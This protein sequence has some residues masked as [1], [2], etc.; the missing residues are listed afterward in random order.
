MLFDFD[1]PSLEWRECRIPKPKKPGEYRKLSIPNDALKAVQ[2]DI[3][4]YLY[5][6]Q[7]LRPSCFAH[8]FVPRR[9]TSTGVARH[10]K[11]A[12]VILCMDVKDFFDNFPL[13]PVKD[14]LVMSGIGEL[15]SAKIITA[16]S[17]KGS[18]PQGGP[19]SPFLT[20]AGMFE[21]DL[22]LSSFA[23]R[24]GFKYSRYADDITLSLDCAEAGK[25]K[26]KNYLF[27]FYGVDKL[28][29][30]TLGLR[31][32]WKKNHTIWK[33][34]REKRQVT[35]VVIRKDGLGYNAPRKLR[36]HV[37]AMAC[38]LARKLQ[39]AGN[40]PEAEDFRV[41]A[42]LVGYVRYF[43]NLRSYST[44]D[45][46]SADPIIQECYWNYLASLFDYKGLGLEKE[47]RRSNGQ[48]E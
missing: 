21:V 28:L 19:C 44:G 38:N 20:N 4:Q 43:D 17:Y 24:H 32:N 34:G 15:L 2:R 1:L 5:T 10:S 42:K 11:D 8:G 3:L 36:R 18:L 9:N 26:R 40:M 39:N 14:R 41:W 27:M 30:K 23:K 33:N 29:S 12:D 48:R 25:D 37:R 22:M 13:K 47:E 6:V 35:G 7:G 46:A 31:L 16:C 45:A